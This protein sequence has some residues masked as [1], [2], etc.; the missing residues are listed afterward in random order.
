M[1]IPMSKN[2]MGA[3]KENEPE[4]PKLEQ[5]KLEFIKGLSGDDRWEAF[6][7]VIDDM[8]SQY[9]NINLVDS[10]TPES[11]GYK[12]LVSRTVIE[13]LEIIKNLPDNLREYER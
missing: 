8:E 3:F 10:D 1:D 7:K 9:R 2:I 4:E 13:V 12:Y 5:E 11:I 6:K